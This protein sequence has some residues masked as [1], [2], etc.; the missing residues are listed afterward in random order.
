[1]HIRFP[2]IVI[3]CWLSIVV[4]TKENGGWFFVNSFGTHNF[5]RR[6]R[7]FCSSSATTTPKFYREAAY[8]REHSGANVNLWIRSC[9]TKLNGNKWDNLV[10]EDDEDEF[11]PQVCILQDVGTFDEGVSIH[12]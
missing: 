11:E 1:M 9:Q 2:S 10:D 6:T 3:S 8:V 4:L 12:L 5:V 7:T